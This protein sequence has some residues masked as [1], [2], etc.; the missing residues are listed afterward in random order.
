LAARLVVFALALAF[1]AVAVSTSAP[2]AR[3]SPVLSWTSEMPMGT[4]IAQAVVVGAANGTVY[5]MGG[6]SDIGYTSVAA[7]YAYDP[8]TG[9]WSTLAPMLYAARGAAGSMGLDGKVYVF[10]GES[11]S[12]YTQ[13]YDPETNAWSLG[14]S[15][16]D[17]AWEAKAA[18]VTNGSIWV[19]GGEGA[20]AGYA[21]IYD[22][23]DDSW[24]V[25]RPVPVAV[26]C[27]ALVAVGDDLYYSGGG[28][29]G[30][31][32]TT[33]F[34]MYDD[35]A[36]SWVTTLHPMPIA[37]AA[38]A[39]VLGVD[40]LIYVVGGSSDAFNTGGGA[41]ATVLVYDPAADEWS[42]A[43][44]MSYARKYLG[45][46]TTPDGRI[47]ALGG[48]TPSAVL[49]VVES[50]QLYEFQYTID[51]SASSARAGETVL[52]TLDAQFTY[53][54]EDFS[55][56]SWHLESVASGTVYNFDSVMIPTN[57][58]TSITVDIPVLAPPGDYAVVVESWT[59]YAAGVYEIVKDEERPLQVLAA[60]E[61]TDALIADLEAQIAALEAQMNNSDANLTAL[62]S[63]IDAL[64]ETLAG[65]NE[66]L[67]A[68]DDKTTETKDSVDSSNIMGYVN[69]A[70]VVVV[71]VLLLAMM[72]MGRKGKA[73]V[74]PAP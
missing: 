41:Y 69:L 14:A 11:G 34:Y 1:I 10:G 43:A 17:G 45:A 3:A 19:V 40:G 72:M 50:L 25:G 5:V 15:M 28:V 53:I 55:V 52:L 46:T 54:D 18:T 67:S 13:I 61:P 58:T 21:Q 48:N 32:G 47:L 65:L 70:L 56:V 73:P 44:D 16:L 8:D 39:M 38:H 20:A 27:G 71:I 22:P 6:V 36:G 29:A 9:D 7:A 51:L 31:T 42:S 30:Y 2:N 60:P 59:I 74:P 12:S 68:V 33:N 57:A 37:R 4:T 24:S 26:E 63:Q 62:Q 64:E 35:S 49:D 23:V 66:K